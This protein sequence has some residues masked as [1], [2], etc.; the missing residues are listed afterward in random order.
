MSRNI[1]INGETM[2]YVKGASDTP[3]AVLQELGLSDAAVSVVPEI[4]HQDINVDAWGRAPIDIQILNGVVNIS[5]TLVHF[6]RDYLATCLALSMGSLTLGAVGR[7]GVRMGGGLARF[8][9]GNSLISL[10]LASPVGLVPWRFFSA[11]LTGP[12][13]EFPLGVER[14]IVRLNWRAIPYVPD[15]WQGGVG[16]TNFPLYDHVLDN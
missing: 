15:P 3:L 5:M 13:L 2:V 10:N 6:D 4:F 9:A 1:F 16:S 12:P 14:S 7:S 8:A 11:Y